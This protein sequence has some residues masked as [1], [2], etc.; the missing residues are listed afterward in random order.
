MNQ[1]S[2]MA[3]Q[4]QREPRIDQ[5]VIE[6]LLRSAWASWHEASDEREVDEL[7]MKLAERASR[8][9]E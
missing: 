8:G 9:N 1:M 2:F 6:T 7:V 5:G 3:L 4:Q